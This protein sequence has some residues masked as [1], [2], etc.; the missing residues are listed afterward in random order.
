MT[1]WQL[2]QVQRAFVQ[3]PRRPGRHPPRP[4]HRI[5]DLRAPVDSIVIGSGFLWQWVQDFWFR[6]VHLLLDAAVVVET[7]LGVECPLTV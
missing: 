7:V 6:T 2:H 5:R 4:L 3:L 1:E